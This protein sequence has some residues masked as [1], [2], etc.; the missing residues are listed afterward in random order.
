MELSNQ[1]KSRARF[2]LGF[3]SPTGI[4]EQDVRQVELSFKDIRDRY[5]YDQIITAIDRCDRTYEK[6]DMTLEPATEK[7]VYVGDLNRAKINFDLA[8]AARQWNEVYLL[9]V[10]K[11]AV[12]LHVPNYR[13]PEIA[14]IR[15]ERTGAVYVQPIPGP[16]DTATISKVE[17]LELISGGSGF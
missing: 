8:S 11:L 9:E 16:A 1:D 17:S 3:A 13:R 2:H 10:D 5:T 12:I 7:Q 15:R 6:T 4:Y 14:E